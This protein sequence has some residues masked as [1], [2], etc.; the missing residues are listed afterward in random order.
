MHFCQTTRPITK[1]GTLTRN[2]ETNPCC[3][4]FPGWIF[5]YDAR[6]SQITTYFY[7]KMGDSSIS[8]L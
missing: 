5:G 7:D 1:F 6:W 4:K 2:S 8:R 3:W